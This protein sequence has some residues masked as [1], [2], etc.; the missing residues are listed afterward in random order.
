M[1]MTFKAGASSVKPPLLANDNAF[2]GD[3]MTSETEPELQIT[4][5]FYRQEKGTPLV[6]T[7]TYD[8]MKIILEGHFTMEDE[9]GY[10]VDAVPG[11]SFYFKKGCTITFTSPDYGLAFFVGRRP[12]G[13]G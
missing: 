4:S 13:S 3:L 5:G 10:K 11:D 9:T 7:Y 8:E 2:L 12:A 6:Y 1:P